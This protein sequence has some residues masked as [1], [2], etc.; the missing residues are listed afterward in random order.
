MT[1]FRKANKNDIQ[2]LQNLNNEVFIDNSQYDSDL[3]LDW[4]LSEKGKN[5]FMKLVNNPESICFIAEENNYPV[6]YIALLP[7]K[8]SY[9]KSKCLEI[10]NM[11][12][13]P[14]YRSKGIGSQLIQKGVVWAKNEGYKKI[15]VNS[16]FNNLKAIAFYK[17]NNFFE[18]DVSLER[19]I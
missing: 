5:Y 3:I 18:I 4:A 11:G 6:G 17:K 16:Y 8:L 19:D 13:I 1:S 9:R 12:V 7:K 15:Y 2:I 14:Q 10:E